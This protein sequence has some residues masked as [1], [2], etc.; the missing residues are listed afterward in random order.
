MLASMRM[1]LPEDMRWLFWEA[2]F[3]SLDSEEHAHYVLARTLE[4]GRM[5]DVRWA[6][7]TYGFARIHAFLRDCGHPEL[8][9]RTLA[10]WRAALRAKDEKWASPPAWRKHSAAHWPG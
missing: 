4:H 5:P 2:D 6:I 7:A 1:R 9:P 10:F 8:S 3:E